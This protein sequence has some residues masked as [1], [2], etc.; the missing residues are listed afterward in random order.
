LVL[1]LLLAL[2]I[3]RFDTASIIRWRQRRVDAGPA[4]PLLSID[5]PIVAPAG[6]PED[7]TIVMSMDDAVDSPTTEDPEPDETEPD[8]TEPHETEPHEAGVE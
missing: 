6:A 4:A 3:S 7:S 2:G 5:A 8:Q 1:W